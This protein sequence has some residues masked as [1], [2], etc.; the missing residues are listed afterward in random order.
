MSI[1]AVLVLLI[2]SQFNVRTSQ[3]NAPSEG[4]IVVYIENNSIAQRIGLK[5]GDV[6]LSEDGK[7]LPYK[8]KYMA[9]FSDSSKSI[10]LTVWRLGDTLK[11]EGKSEKAREYLGAN[12]VYYTDEDM[13]SPLEMREDVDTLISVI[14]DVHPNPFASLS[15]EEFEALKNRIYEQTLDSMSIVEFWELLASFVAK[16]GDGHTYVFLPRDIFYRDLFIRDE[17][18]IFPFAIKI[19]KDT[20]IVLK[21]YSNEE[22]IKPGD[23][24]VSINNVPTEAIVDSLITFTSGELR[25][26]RV[27]LAKKMFKGM[28]YYIYGW[29]DTFNIK[30]LRRD[31]VIKYTIA[32][33][34]REL[35]ERMLK[36]YPGNRGD[37]F[38]FR[39]MPDLRTAVLV[40]RT[41]A[42]E[43]REKFN[44]FLKESFRKIQKQGYKYLIVDVRENLGG[45]TDVV[46]DLLS[47]IN[48][49][50]YR[51]FSM[52]KEKCN[53]Q[54]GFDS[55]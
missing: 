55:A 12:C 11:I 38:E 31:K 53:Y 17:K 40:I 27:S 2:N 5:H 19:Y 37:A 36:D 26:F 46:E 8:K 25:H 32:A 39:E 42:A 9:L 14:L 35:F 50:P 52:V 34:D 10:N 7:S 6:I 15:R 4:Y 41:F 24:I 21:N 3:K 16:L 18:I 48:D 33:G 29:K 13:L 20:L 54:T 30:V 1:I 43:Y 49:K 23:L 22:D 47:Y 44:K 45:S 51:M 28:L